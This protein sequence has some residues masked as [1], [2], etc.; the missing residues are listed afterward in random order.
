M[1]PF[2]SSHVSKGR[3]IQTI[4]SSFILPPLSSPLPSSTPIPPPPPS[5][6][7]IPPPHASLAEFILLPP[8]L[9]N[10][11]SPTSGYHYSV[12]EICHICRRCNSPSSTINTY[13]FHGFP[14]TN[15]WD[16][17]WPFSSTPTCTIGLAN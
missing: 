15:R 16:K 10:F 5:L 13:T 2:V 4:P 1:V 3:V 7:H 6:A 11:A 17:L 9:A 12:K 14:S 8:S